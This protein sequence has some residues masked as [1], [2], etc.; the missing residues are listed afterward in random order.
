MSTY[1]KQLI[2]EKDNRFSIIIENDGRVAYAYL[3]DQDSIIGDVWLY[4][5][6][7][8]P[9][10]VD[11]KDIEKA[12]FLNSLKYTKNDKSLIS[13]RFIDSAKTFWNIHKTNV[14]VLI[15]F[16]NGLKVILENGAKPGWS[17]N[18]FKDGPLAKLLK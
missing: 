5:Q 16:E 18:V 6:I 3:L 11:W 17:N 2:C 4:N 12:P 13:N 9:N 8:T 7:N 14:Q 10:I 15:Q 1:F